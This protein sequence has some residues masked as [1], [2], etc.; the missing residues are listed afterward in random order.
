[1]SKQLDILF[2]HPA[3]NR[4]N[5]QELSGELAAV[6]TP[7]WAG[8]I[9]SF[10]RQKGYSI[11]LIDAEAMELTPVQVADRVQKENPVLTAIIVYG[12][13]PSASTQNMPGAR[14]IC[15][16]IKN[17]NPNFKTIFVGGHVAAL[18][19]LTLKE[20]SCDFVAK[21]EGP[22]TIID[23]VELLKSSQP[24]QFEKVR[25]LYY[26]KDGQVCST[27]APAIVQNL[28][29]EMP[30]VAWDLLPMEKYRA[31]NWHAF[32]TMKRQPYASIY[33][34]LGCPFHCSFCCIQAPFKDGEQ[35]IG[36]KAATNS[37]RFWSV[38][39]TAD[40][41]Q[42]LVEKHGVRNLKIAD[43]MFVLN[44]KYISN[45][46]DAII[47]RG[48]DLNIWCYARVDTIKDGMLE[49]LKKAG[50][51][52]LALG[53][54]SGSDRVRNEVSKSL[55]QDAIRK[56][57]KEI[58]DMGMYVIGNYIF[59]LPEDDRQS[60]QETLD[61]A[62]ELNCEFANIYSAMA[63]PGS[64]LYTQAVTNNWKL[65]ETWSGYA[66]LA[67]DSF[68]LPTKYLSSEEVLAFRDEAFYKYFNNP[69]YLSMIRQKFGA[70]TES[71]IKE[72]AQKRI[73]RKFVTDSAVSTR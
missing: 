23:L 33:T 40:Q 49:K 16:E 29:V 61:L 39:K 66:Q 14:V 17:R 71:H 68:P 22:Y 6:E 67:Y 70:D 62:L 45:F 64:Q 55:S 12:H 34:T 32:D 50:V 51:Q 56:V 8:L 3:N 11:D 63:Y 73:K 18:P 19:E 31:H 44:S 52:W 4:I 25:G 5:Y 53:I 69:K 47:S 7:I 24:D 21:G 35:A 42:M 1:M 72:M 48:L 15:N 41:L 58:Q 43:E 60:M 46:C 13:N 37:Y 28:D 36:Y 20:E 65:P 54:E 10:A 9:A 59:G 30:G 2:V 38:E 27:P 26:R 57:V